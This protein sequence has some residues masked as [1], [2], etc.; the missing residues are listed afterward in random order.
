MGNTHEGCSK[1]KQLTI[2]IE[3]LSFAKSD[4]PTMH[5]T[6]IQH[7]ALVL[8]ICARIVPLMIEA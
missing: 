7:F 3:L 1:A 6:E 4:D 5:T 2:S 8:Q